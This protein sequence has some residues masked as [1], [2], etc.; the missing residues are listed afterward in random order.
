MTNESVL[1]Y[2]FL[3][4]ELVMDTVFG[5]ELHLFLPGTGVE[6]FGMWFFF[7]FLGRMKLLLQHICGMLFVQNG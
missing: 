1:L 3:S 6:A 5:A 7:C 4:L 2:P